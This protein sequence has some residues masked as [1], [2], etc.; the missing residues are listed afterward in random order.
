[1]NSIARN[2]T[3][4]N[5]CNHAVRCVRTMED[6]CKANRTSSSRRAAIR[7]Q[8]RRR[9]LMRRLRTMTALA[10]LLILIPFCMQQRRPQHNF[11]AD[12]AD[13]TILYNGTFYEE[14]LALSEE[15]S[16]VM[17]ILEQPEAYPERLLEMV[18]TT[19]EALDFVLNYPAEKDMEHPISIENTYE[20]GKIPLYIQW[21]R[22][23]GYAS[24]GNGMIALDG[25]GPTC[26]SMV[27]V[28]LTGDTSLNPK[29]MADYSVRNG[30][31]T[32]NAATSWSLM[33]YGAEAL[34]LSSKE[35]PLDSEIIRRELNAGHPIIC[36]MRPGDFTTTGHF[37]VLTGVSAD[38]QI[39]VN[40]P[41]SP[42]RSEKT[43][44][45]ASILPQIKNLWSFSI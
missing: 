9:R 23:W 25:C 10:V 12:A 8:R 36:S 5:D 28:G 15:H 42:A 31:I 45:L 24:Y 21:D 6:G 19:P 32:E 41:N 1:M 11:H 39:T 35:L 26:L 16:E 34:G 17:N 29:A 18:V 37:I 22:Q 14:L 20:E 27:F 43:W 44:E 2:H 7:K 40:D 30:Y 3:F 13:N 38:G 4:Y 33:T